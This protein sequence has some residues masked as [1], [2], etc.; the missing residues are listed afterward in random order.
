MPA[1]GPFAAP[2]CWASAPAHPSHPSHPS[3]PH[4]TLA[5]SW[6]FIG[7]AA[8]L[9]SLFANL[10]TLMVKKTG[11][12]TIEALAQAASNTLLAHLVSLAF[13]MV[14]TRKIT[15]A[16]QKVGSRQLACCG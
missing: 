7:A 3:H 4:P 15:Q 6:N 8:T 12:L 2:A 11:S 10:G 9:T 13:L 14:V 5:H 16:Y 1:P